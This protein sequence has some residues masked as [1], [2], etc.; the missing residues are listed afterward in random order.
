LF[1]RP[2]LLQLFETYIATCGDMHETRARLRMPRE[3]FLSEFADIVRLLGRAFRE[4]RPYPLFPTNEY[5]CRPYLSAPA[6]L[7]A[8]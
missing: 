6:L 8:A 2:E 3:T 1:G 7:E 5:F 4:V